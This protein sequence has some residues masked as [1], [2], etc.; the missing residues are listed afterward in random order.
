MRPQA[1]FDTETGG[2]DPSFSLLQLAVLA[3]H[4]GKIVDRLNM[5]LR[6]EPLVVTAK[7]METNKI[8][9]GKTDGVFTDIEIA[10]G[11]YR[12]FMNRNFFYKWEAGRWVNVRPSKDNMPLFCGHNTFF[13]RPFMKKFMGSDFD[14]CYYHRVDTMVLASTL[15]D[16]G[17]LPDLENCKLETLAAYFNLPKPER[18]HDA[19]CDVEQTFMLYKCL[20]ELIRGRTLDDVRRSVATQPALPFAAPSAG[21]DGAVAAQAH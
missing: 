15:K 18:F 16:A 4:N 14:F 1:W 11:T 17:L 5:Q 12:A 2:L 6:I 20:Q 21:G 8:D 13:D 3:V 7:A 19:L 9:L 10:R